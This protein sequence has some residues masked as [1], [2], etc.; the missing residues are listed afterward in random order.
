MSYLSKWL[1]NARSIAL[2]QSLLPSLLAVVFAISQKNFN[3][4]A[5]LLAVIGVEAAHL[6]MNLLDDYFDYKADMLSDRDRVIRKG[7]RAMMVKYPYLTDGSET[8]R[9]TKKAIGIF[10]AIASICAI[11]I[12]FI[13]LEFNTIAWMVSIA[14]LAA[15]LGWFYSAPPFKLAYR[16][17]GELVIGV[18]FGPLLMSGVYV[19]SSAVMDTQIVW[20]SL[21]V[22]LLVVNILYTHSLIERESDKE[23]NKMTFARLLG[24]DNLA[25]TASYIFNI[26]PFALIIAAV[27]LR[28]LHPAFLAVFV[29]LPTAIW[30]CRSLKGFVAGQTD[31]P[32]CPPKYLGNMGNWD[33]IRAAG[34]DWFMMR[35]LAARNLLAS[36][37]AIMIIVKIILLI[38]NA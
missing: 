17:L 37:C 19:A 35:W 25:V 24:K 20:I 11:A 23:S 8:P 14:L 22:G 2:L 10:L 21:P 5:A 3:I 15:F 7:F 31:V 32:K 33:E 16:G 38:C 6:A 36:F 30:L 18:I 1:K 26:L 29:L 9:T 13:R 12:F 28:F 34:V 4:F 27:C